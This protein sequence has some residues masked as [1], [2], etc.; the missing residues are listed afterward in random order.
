MS[1]EARIQ[2][3]Q[4]RLRRACIDAD[5]DPSTVELL[6]VSKR[7]PEGLIRD[8]MALGFKRFG[9]NY[10][11]EAAP[12]AAALP[13]AAFVLIGPLQSNK[14]KLALQ[15][16]AEIQSVDRLDLA[17]R[18]DRL[19]RELDICRPTWI[20]V[21]LWHEATKQGGC[22]REQLPELARYLAECPRLPLQGFMAIP[23]PGSPEAFRELAALREDWSRR[24]G[25]KLRLSMGMSDDLEAAVAAGSDQIRIGTAFFGAR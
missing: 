10:V 8:A 5:R 9:E 12:K 3:V 23:P 16:F 2:Q 15:T 20:Q 25:R 21:D 19:A 11:Q 17:K 18:L 22:P 14:A 4:D 1:L 24:L 7:Q 6:P 13:Q